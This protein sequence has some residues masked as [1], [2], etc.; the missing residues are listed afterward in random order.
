MYVYSIVDEG[1]DVTIAMSRFEVMSQLQGTFTR[2]GL[3]MT[4]KLFDEALGNRGVGIVYVFEK[5][6]DGE[7]KNDWYLKVESH[8]K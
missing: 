1:Y 3:P 4:K 7:V 8:R 2:E 5:D 6:E